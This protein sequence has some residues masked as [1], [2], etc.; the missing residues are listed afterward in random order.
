MEKIVN[1]KVLEASIWRTFTNKMVLRVIFDVGVGERRL[2]EW[3]C[4]V[5]EEEGKPYLLYEVMNFFKVQSTADMEGAVCRIIGPGHQ[6]IQGMINL[7]DDSFK[8]DG[9]SDQNDFGRL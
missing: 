3:Q 6:Y 2:R 7:F 1:A 5:Q 4:P 9:P 8:I